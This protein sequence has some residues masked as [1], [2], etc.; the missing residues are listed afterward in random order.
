MMFGALLV[1][2]SCESDFN[3]N[4]IF[5]IICKGIRWL[6]TMWTISIDIFPYAGGAAKEFLSPN[7]H[8]QTKF[9]CWMEF[10]SYKYYVEYPWSLLFSSLRIAQFFS[11]PLLLDRSERFMGATFAPHFWDLNQMQYFFKIKAKE[12]RK[13][14]TSQKWISCPDV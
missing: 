11:Q 12:Q 5:V 1:Q 9:L 8:C 4:F 3:D 13:L 2:D 10:L 7:F 6:R 14:R